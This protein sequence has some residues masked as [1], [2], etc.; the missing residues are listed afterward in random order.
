M[1]LI[2]ERRNISQMDAS[3]RQRSSSVEC[4]EG[5]WNQAA[6]GSKEDCRVQGLR[7]KVFGSANA[8]DAKFEGEL[9]VLF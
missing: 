4:G 8:G 6:D 5:N 2:V 3:N 7:W 1:A 9:T